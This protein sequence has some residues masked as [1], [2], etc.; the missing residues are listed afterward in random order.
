MRKIFFQ[1]KAKGLNWQGVKNFS[2]AKKNVIIKP[3]TV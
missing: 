1:L 2:D 3:Y